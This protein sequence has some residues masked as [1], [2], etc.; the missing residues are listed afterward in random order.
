MEHLIKE[1]IGSVL[2]LTLNRPDSLN[3]FSEEMILGL[4][5]ELKN[6]EKNANVKV[7][8]LNGAGR[9]ILCRR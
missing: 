8:V 3:A 2:V 5:K 9:A 7:I 1:E 6:A 4:T